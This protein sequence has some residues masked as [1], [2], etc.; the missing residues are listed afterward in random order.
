MIDPV[1]YEVE[2]K[3]KGEAPSQDKLLSLLLIEDMYYPPGECCQGV[4]RHTYTSKLSMMEVTVG[5]LERTVEATI[6]VRVVEG[7]WPSQYHA[8]FVAPMP[9]LDDLGMVLLDS[10]GGTVTVT[11]DG[12]IE[13]SRRVVSVE[14]KGELRISVDACLG[15]GDGKAGGV[16]VANGQVSFAPRTSGRSKGV[17]DVGFC[18][19]EVVVVWSLVVNW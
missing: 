16:F 13:L 19:M 8:R 3:V 6:A 10:R 18:R 11:S 14:E 2:L 4:H 1:Y 15:G 5:H 17:C 7:S 9:S 12:V